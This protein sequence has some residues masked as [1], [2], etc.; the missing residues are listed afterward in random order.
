MYF[1]IYPVVAYRAYCY[2]AI[3]SLY[4][5]LRQALAW[6]QVDPHERHDAA[7]TNKN[8]CTKEMKQA[9]TKTSFHIGAPTFCNS[10]PDDIRSKEMFSVV[11]EK[12]KDYST[13][14]QNSCKP[15]TS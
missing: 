11:D 5:Q 1:I 7:E 15:Q 14:N 13:E 9:I 4:H 6:R 3:Y 2:V 10:I 12:F 8:L